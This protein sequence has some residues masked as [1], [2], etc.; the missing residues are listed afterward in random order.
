[1]KALVG[2]LRARLGSA[3]NAAALVENGLQLGRWVYLA[4]GVLL[5]P[6]FCW[7]ISIGDN[8]TL[9]PR[10]HVLAHDASTRFHLGYTRIAPVHIGRRA[11][12]GASSIILPGVTV[13]DDTVIG[14]GS[15]VTKSVGPGV[16][17]VGNPARV[18]GD[19]A[20]YIAAHEQ[21]LGV[22]P[23]YE[24]KG[25]T[26]RGGITASNKQRMRVELHDGEGYVR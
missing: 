6:D 16:V 14:A 21:R 18:R 20:D 9:A 15:V 13:G 19:V 17:A 7:L 23:C 1:M 24:A 11:F 10:V 4:P 22:R 12:I 26:V 8:A 5:D 2:R 3:P 25:W